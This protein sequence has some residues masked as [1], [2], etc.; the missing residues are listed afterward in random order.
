MEYH[1]PKVLFEKDGMKFS[2]IT[3][4]KYSMIFS[5]ENKNIILTNVINLN[6]IKLIYDLNTDVYESVLF[7]KINEN[8]A[9][10]TLL[11]KNFFEDLGLPQKYAYLYIIKSVSNNTI[12]FNSKS[13]QTIG[14][15]DIPENAEILVIKDNICLCEIITPHKVNFTFTV[16]F[17]DNVNIPIFLEK[18]IG[19]ILNKIF[20]R[21]KQFI[22]NITIK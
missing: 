15:K 8:E 11:F 14:P 12:I 17:E 5:M 20:K 21:V 1:E 19:F 7:E 16:L 9:N 3:N 6:L 13:I 2:K 18:M 4:N 10:I 22:E